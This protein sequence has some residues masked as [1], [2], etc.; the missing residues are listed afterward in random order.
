MSLRINLLQQILENSEFP[1]S[2]LIQG[3]IQSILFKVDL[4]EYFVLSLS[5]SLPSPIFDSKNHLSW[6]IKLGKCRNAVH[7]GQ[8]KMQEIKMGS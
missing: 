7:M 6:G 2:V 5:F 8:Q 3:E 1:Q 4:T